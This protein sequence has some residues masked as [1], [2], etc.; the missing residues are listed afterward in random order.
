MIPAI[1]DVTDGRIAP[2]PAAMRISLPSLSGRRRAL[3]TEDDEDGTV[4][5]YRHQYASLPPLRGGTD[6]SG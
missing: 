6:R 5:I 3:L 2:P 4:S 1:R